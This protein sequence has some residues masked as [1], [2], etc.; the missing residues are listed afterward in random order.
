MINSRRIRSG[1]DPLFSVSWTE[2]RIRKIKEIEERLH[3]YTECYVQNYTTIRA[4]TLSKILNSPNPPPY[5]YQTT[6]TFFNLTPTKVTKDQR[7][8]FLPSYHTTVYKLLS[9]RTPFVFVLV[10]TKHTTGQRYHIY[11]DGTG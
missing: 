3:Y 10:L 9:V 8:E 4:V 1:P 2:I 6:E 5:L 11:E 7:S